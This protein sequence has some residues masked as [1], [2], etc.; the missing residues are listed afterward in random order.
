M[1]Y[2]FQMTKASPEKLAITSELLR[3]EIANAVSTPDPT[4]QLWQN[5][6]R[7]N[8]HGASFT[9]SH[10]PHLPFIVTQSAPFKEG[11][12]I[13]VDVRQYYDTGLA[14]ESVL[15][16][17]KQGAPLRISMNGH[18]SNRL[19]LHALEQEDATTDYFV[20]QHPAFAISEEE[21]H[22]SAVAL[23]AKQ[24]PNFTANLG[25]IGLQAAIA[26]TIS[27]IPVWPKNIAFVE[28]TTY[29]RTQRTL[30]NLREGLGFWLEVSERRTT[31]VYSELVA[32]TVALRRLFAIE[33]ASGKITNG[34]LTNTLKIVQDEKWGK[35]EAKQTGGLG[36]FEDVPSL[37]NPTN[38]PRLIPVPD[39]ERMF[40]PDIFYPDPHPSN[41][42]VDWFVHFVTDPL[43]IED[44]VPKT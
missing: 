41:R 31:G 29:V 37:V 23:L 33:R 32:V 44:I 28:R 6:D 17:T 34:I 16:A 26:T 4:R 8:W 5:G 22:E 43:D 10:A 20:E 39:E 7:K 19:S 1:W 35:I 18:S 42:T 21:Y 14:T 36:F 12:P 25:E 2:K 3:S 40:Y 24:N 27:E 9:L 15:W 38:T 30:Q 13:K 11:D